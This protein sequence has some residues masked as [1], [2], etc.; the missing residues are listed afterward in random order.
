M[1]AFANSVLHAYADEVLTEAATYT[2]SGGTAT[3]VR[4]LRRTRDDAVE[5]LGHAVRHTG[6]AF[7]IAVA[8]VASL[9]EGDTLT[10]DAVARTVRHVAFGPK[11]LWALLWVE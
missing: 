6:Q 8:A 1:T 9:T 2:P 3:A 4:V 5:V 11:R 10:H 7:Q